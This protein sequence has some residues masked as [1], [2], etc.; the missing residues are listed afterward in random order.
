[1]ASKVLKVPNKEKTHEYGKTL[2]KKAYGYIN[3]I[4]S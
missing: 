2:P 4:S 3:S 1:M